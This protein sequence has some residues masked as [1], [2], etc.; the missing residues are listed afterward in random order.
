MKGWSSKSCDE[1]TGLNIGGG[2]KYITLG[3]KV[4][5]QCSANK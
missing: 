5:Y 2:F 3:G 1:N 4:V